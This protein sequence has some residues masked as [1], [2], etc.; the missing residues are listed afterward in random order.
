MAASGNSIVR[1]GPEGASDQSFGGTSEL[2]FGT[3]PA[4][5]G[6]AARSFCPANI[7]VDGHGRL[8][9]FGGESDSRRTFDFGLVSGEPVPASSALVLRYSGAGNLDPTFGGG[10]GYV[11]GGLNL[12]AGV[13]SG[14]DPG[15]ARSLVDAL[16]GAVD[17]RD[18][19]VLV[20]GVGSVLSGCHGHA[21]FEFVPRAVVRLTESGGRDLG[22]G[23][24]GRASVAGTA[25]FPTV[26]TDAGGGVVAKV[27]PSRGGL[28]RCRSETTLVRLGASGNR[29]P[30]FGER[31][32][33]RLGQ[34]RLALVEPSGASIVYRY[35]G[36]NLDLARIGANG[37]RSRSFG[38]HG[39]AVVRLPPG[40]AFG[41]RPVAVDGSGRILL[42]G[43]TGGGHSTIVIG[44]VLPDGRLDASFGE[45]GWLT[46]PVPGSFEIGSL[47]AALDPA[48][49]LLIAA[50]GAQAGENEHSY[51]LARFL[52]GS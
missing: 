27:G 50:A 8:L 31:G 28:S 36:R 21:G 22:F 45:G 2:F 42:A 34:L 32:A 17:S 11:R 20:A 23:N 15:K 49:R 6:I 1:F 25:R 46:P 51:L 7:A 19:P 33:L 4:A 18:R 52:L 47:A 48:G 24:G 35:R 39:L 9:V 12:G 5:D 43:Y 30:M 3:D 40:A 44:R 13:H 26:A 10:K 41:V 38:Q 37:G 29:L 16:A 14:K